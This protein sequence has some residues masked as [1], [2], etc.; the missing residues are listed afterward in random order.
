M[1]RFLDKVCNVVPVLIEGTLDC[2]QLKG[3]LDFAY[4]SLSATYKITFGR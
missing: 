3:H 2:V 4:V 1:T